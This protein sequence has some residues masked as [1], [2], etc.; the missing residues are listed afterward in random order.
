M[1]EG[2]GGFRELGDPL[3][4]SPQALPH[5]PRSLLKAIPSPRAFGVGWEWEKRILLIIFN[6]IYCTYLGGVWGGVEGEEGSLPLPLP[7]PFSTAIC[8]C[9]S[10]PPPSPVIWMCLYFLSVSSLLLPL[11]NPSAPISH[12][13]ALALSW[14]SCT[15]QLVYTGTHTT[16][17]T[18]TQRQTLYRWLECLC[19]A[20]S[21]GG[22]AVAGMGRV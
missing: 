17:Q 15:T 18:K 21:L 10:P 13:P 2:A 19:P 14:A 4:P 9:L 16:S 20:T 1:V 7:L 11:S 8:L 6:L 22:V 5:R 12:H 3:S